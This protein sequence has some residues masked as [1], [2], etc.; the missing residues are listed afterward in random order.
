MLGTSCSPYRTRSSG[1]QRLN[2]HGPPRKYHRQHVARRPS[3]PFH[4]PPRWEWKG[5]RHPDPLEA[6]T[7]RARLRASAREKRCRR[8]IEGGPQKDSWQNVSS[9]YGQPGGCKAFRLYGWVK[10]LFQVE[11]ACL[12][13]Y[14]ES[15]AASARAVR[16]HSAR[17]I[18]RGNGT[19][20]IS[21]DGGTWSAQPA[22]IAACFYRGFL[23]QQHAHSFGKGT[24]LTSPFYP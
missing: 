21:P 8:F 15:H 2:A 4:R 10:V 5:T 14:E 6:P 9:R 18:P 12:P 22:Y 13:C 23:C 20:L 19:I 16:G 24:G 7:Q 1:L 17:H 3:P 11:G